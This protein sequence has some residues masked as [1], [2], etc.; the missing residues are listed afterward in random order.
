LLAYFDDKIIIPFIENIQLPLSAE[1]LGQVSFVD[2]KHQINPDENAN[3]PLR[4]T[5]LSRV[6]QPK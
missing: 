6:H 5:D 1:M 2:L 3:V 4:E